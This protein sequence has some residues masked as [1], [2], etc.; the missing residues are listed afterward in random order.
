MTT[1]KS[2]I[3]LLI[4]HTGGG[5]NCEWGFCGHVFAWA[6]VFLSV[7]SRL[8]A[9]CIRACVK[10]KSH[11]AF[12]LR[13]NIVLNRYVTLRYAVTDTGDLQTTEILLQLF[14]DSRYS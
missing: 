6:C 3:Q 11:E 14:N 9:E 7:Q 10:R 5:E 2:H 8:I 4:K 1:V 13:F 12:F